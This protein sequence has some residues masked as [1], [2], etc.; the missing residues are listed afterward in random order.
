MN[1][2]ILMAM[3]GRKQLVQTN[4]ELLRKQ[5]CKVVVITSTDPDYLFIR[6]LDMPNVEIC[7]APNHP[8][9]RK[10]QIGLDYCKNLNADPVV[11][12]GSDDFL[13]DRFVE[14]ALSFK[15]LDFIF[16]TQWHIHDSVG[17]KDYFL[18][19]KNV[20]PL[21]SGR[22]FFK[23]FLDKN[24]WI[25]FD[26][27]RDRLLDD[28][29]YEVVKYEDKI[30][31]NPDGMKLLSVKG[32]WETMNPMEKILQASDKIDWWPELNIDHHFGFERKIKDIFQ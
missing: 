16:F 20:F 23:R 26:K 29:A 21:G 6:D 8:L 4:L 10:W 2:V 28:Y 31:M 22:V 1:P 13:S 25:L 7:V 15:E 30:L 24:G 19:Y 11:V 9:G 17:K 14:K 3:Y 5:K 32:S 12:V 18:K 27:E